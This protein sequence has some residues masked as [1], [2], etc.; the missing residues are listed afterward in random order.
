M[1]FEIKL[2]QNETCPHT[3]EF[4]RPVPHKRKYTCDDKFMRQY[5]AHD[6]YCPSNEN[7]R[8]FEKIKRPY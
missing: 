8:V 4:K 6:T 5:Y 1:E 7:N 3:V 2:S